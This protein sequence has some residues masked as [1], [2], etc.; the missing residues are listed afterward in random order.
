MTIVW[1]SIL[2][3]G[4]AQVGGDRFGRKEGVAIPL[5]DDTNAGACAPIQ[6]PPLPRGLSWI[7]EELPAAASPQA[8]W[9]MRVRVRGLERGSYAAAAAADPTE[10]VVLV[11]GGPGQSSA[12]LAPLIRIASAAAAATAGG[13]DS[14]GS[15]GSRGHIWATNASS[16]PASSG[17]AV[18]LYDQAGSGRSAALPSHLAGNDGARAK[19][20]TGEGAGGIDSVL[21]R[22][23][24]ELWVV[25]RRFRP[26]VRRV[27]LVG[28]SFG[29]TIALEAARELARRARGARANTPSI[30]LGSLSLLSPSIDI[31]A[32]ARDARWYEWIEGGAKG[33]GRGNGN[34]NGNGI[35]T[36]GELLGPVQNNSPGSDQGAKQER[37]GR[38]ER[39]DERYTQ[40]HV[41]RHWQLAAVDRL[42]CAPNGEVYDRLWGA[43][44]ACPNGLVRSYAEVGALSQVARTAGIPVLLVAGI[45]DEVPPLRLDA[46]DRACGRVLGSGQGTGN[47]TS[48]GACAGVVLP[49]SAH[50]Y[51][52]TDWTVLTAGIRTLVVGARRRAAAAALSAASD[53]AAAAA[54]AAGVLSA[55]ATAAADAAR[56]GRLRGAL[57]RCERS[58]SIVPRSYGY[59]GRLVSGA[60]TPVSV[61]RQAGAREQKQ[62]LRPGGR[63]RRDADGFDVLDLAQASL[64][65][66]Y[67]GTVVAGGA[68]GRGAAAALGV[69]RPNNV[70]VES[71]RRGLWQWGVPQ[72]SG[73]SGSMFAADTPV[74]PVFWYIFAE[75]LRRCARSTAPGYVGWREVVE[76]VRWDVRD[77]AERVLFTYLLTHVVLYNTDWFHVAPRRGTA[78]GDD[79]ADATQWLVRLAPLLLPQGSGGDDEEAAF[80]VVG[81]VLVCV[82]RL[83]G[84]HH[85]LARALHARLL[86]FVRDG[87]LDG[88]EA[89][90]NK[91]H[92]LVV[93]T[94]ALSI[95]EGKDVY[96]NDVDPA[97]VHGHFLFPSPA[98]PRYYAW[99]TQY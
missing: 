39:A 2:F 69:L 73:P 51:Y 83:L 30:A 20:R 24:D 60:R 63:A 72:R 92:L 50:L 31:P 38:D 67:V 15:G 48:R 14:D 65:V 26:P 36:I 55:T 1:V 17:L 40:L 77:P 97:Q 79:V 61:L 81:E 74:K 54:L 89:W 18:V 28:H 9:A 57:R 68:V 37:G 93:T 45:H 53:A 33:K 46:F 66:W 86:G 25:L 75:T 29:A 42:I 85:A 44:E 90:R 52:G 96:G 58:A 5:R 49:R 76:H 64:D 11:H 41:I 87:A 62:W 32:W 12:Y 88:A 71:V 70:I 84:R 91:G 35:T 95:M 82:A 47:L 6:L 80:D 59:L 7:R 99:S 21:S 22:Y 78:R 98:T 4:I 23:V 56:L 13:S 16:A 3:V 34:G 27:H 10:A 94:A 43:S 19:T 8:P